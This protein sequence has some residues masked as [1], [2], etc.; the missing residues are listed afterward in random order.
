MLESSKA[1]VATLAE[2]VLNAETCPEAEIE[3]AC[4]L[5]VLAFEDLRRKEGNGAAILTYGRL[6]AQITAGE[7]CTLYCDLAQWTR[8]KAHCSGPCPTCGKPH[9]FWF[10]DETSSREFIISGMCQ[11]CQDEFFV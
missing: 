2:M 9:T 6:V 11:E 4:E 1:L 7:N 3:E 5:V 10:R 8:E